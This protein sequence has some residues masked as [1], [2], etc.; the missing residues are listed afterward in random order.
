MDVL[1]VVAPVFALI[2]LGYVAS[3]VR[4]LS[5]GAHKGLSDFAFGIAVPALMLR[6]IATA[7]FP[8]VSPLRVWIAYY[9]AIAFTWLL[10]SLAARYALRRAGPDS[11]VISITSVYGNIV[12]LGIPLSLAAFGPEAAGPMALILAVNTP[13]LWL[14]GIL[15]MSVV[16]A[17]NETGLARR[18]AS[19]R[20]DL[21][22]NP[23]IL[24]MLGGAVL[25]VAD[26]GMHP[27]ADKTLSLVAQAAVPASLIA[28]GAGLRKFRVEGQVPLLGTMCLLKLLVM[29]LAA[30]WFALRVFDLPE[31][32]AGVVVIFAAMPAGANAF[33]FA[34]RYGRVVDS[35]SGA[36]A[37]GTV[38]SALTVSAVIGALL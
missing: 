1:L 17:R 34:S 21:I 11:V 29:P 15:Q 10:A 3:W 37:L 6:V 20:T 5:D 13:L 30:G 32:A 2:V 26:V 14:M 27:V 16:D 7:E 38:I 24:G 31:V 33:L 28:L 36:I 18:V 19:L 9:G 8:E 25:R 23:I 12:M 4:L 35:T 22:R